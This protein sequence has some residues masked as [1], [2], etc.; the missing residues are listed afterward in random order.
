M[1][2]RNWVSALIKKFKE[3]GIV[4]D[5]IRSDRLKKLTEPALRDVT[6]KLERSPTKSLRRL[7]QETGLSFG[8]T[9]SAVHKLK[10]H[11]YKV[12]VVH[13]LKAHDTESRVNFCEWFTAF[14][15]GKGEHTG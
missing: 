14:V 7:S 6:N 3:I 10:F 9:H 4:C 12:H 2:H 8:S 11:P 5:K 15:A 13:E 1:P